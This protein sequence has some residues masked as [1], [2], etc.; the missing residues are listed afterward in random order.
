MDNELLSYLLAEL[1]W[2]EVLLTVDREDDVDEAQVSQTLYNL[3][4]VPF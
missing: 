3:N 2:C 1:L 4:A